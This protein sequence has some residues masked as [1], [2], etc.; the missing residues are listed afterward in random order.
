[1]PEPDQQLDRDDLDL[2]YRQEYLKWIA[3]LS[4]TDRRQLIAM[5][6]DKPHVE[7]TSFAY[8][9]G[10]TFRDSPGM[11]GIQMDDHGAGWHPGLPVPDDDADDIDHDDLDK[12]GRCNP[13]ALA[14]LLR[15]LIVPSVTSGIQPKAIVARVI[16]LAHCLH[17][18]GIGD[19]S[20]D[21]LAQ[22]IGCTRALLSF[23]VT[24]LRD[25]GG[26]D[27]RAGKS[28]EARAAYS[29]AQLWRRNREARERREVKKAGAVPGIDTEKITEG[30]V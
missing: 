30:A 28:V 19:L 23:Y 9:R 5:G 24:Q 13:E 1:M 12:L 26:L 6:L 15:V 14:I 16:A 25:Y 8:L 20:L 17:L 11:I 10:E 7:R 29:A 18:Q 4:S 27:H 22:R 21:A 3:G 2:E